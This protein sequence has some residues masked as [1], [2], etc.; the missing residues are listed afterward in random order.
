MDRSSSDDLISKSILSDRRSSEPLFT[1]SPIENDN[2]VAS[3]TGYLCERGRRRSSGLS[4]T[5]QFT[6]SGSNI[7][8][9]CTIED[10]EDFGRCTTMCCNDI[11]MY[12]ETCPYR[13]TSE[14]E[15]DTLIC[16][17][18]KTMF[19]FYCFSNNN[20]RTSA[21]VYAS[22][23]GKVL[24]NHRHCSKI[25]NIGDIEFM[26]IGPG[27]I[28]FGDLNLS[29]TEDYI[30][31]AII[32]KIKEDTGAMFVLISGNVDRVQNATSLSEELGLKLG[33]NLF[34]STKPVSVKVLS[35]MLEKYKRYLDTLSDEDST[36]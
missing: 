36:C 16:K 29:A 20:K 2:T 15:D 35:D 1:I 7:S 3:I 23:G 9:L 12:E 11:R 26:E 24:G 30:Y 27:T 25:I 22:L 17:S 14:K 5:S 32:D 28:L 19:R 6:G 10:I 18:S 31:P 21:N 13:G 4:S 33:K 8:S 34:I